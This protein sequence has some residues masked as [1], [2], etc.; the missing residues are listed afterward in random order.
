MINAQN[1]LLYLLLTIILSTYSMDI[2]SE[3]D[4]V[5]EKIWKYE[6]DFHD[7]TNTVQA[8]PKEFENLLLFVDGEGHFFALDKYTG[9]LIYSVK[10]GVLAGRRGF[11]VDQDSGNVAIVASDAAR[12][13]LNADATLF[14]IDARSGE[15]LNQTSTDWGVVEP[16]ISE[17]CIITFGA[18]DG[19]IKCYDRK[20]EEIIWQ[21]ELGTYARIWSNSLLSEKHNILYFVTSDAGDIV[22]KDRTEDIYSSALVGINVKTGSIIFSRQMIKDGVW[23][24]DG[25]GKPI[26]IEGFQNDDEN[27]YDMI[28][29]LNK[30]GTI[31]ALN[32]I[33][34]S[35]IKTNQFEEFLF[36]DDAE[37]SLIS[38]NTQV[39]PNW[40]D[41]VIDVS[42]ELD[43]LRMNEASFD[44]LRHVKYGDFIPPSVDY[45][46]ITRGLHGGPQWFGGEYFRS[47]EEDFLAI[48]YNN[49]AWILRNNY[50]EDFWIG[51]KIYSVILRIK[52]LFNYIKNL[53]IED[54]S[55][56]VPDDVDIQSGHRWIQTE[57]SNSG[58]R[59]KTMDFLYKWMNIKA[60][61]KNYY[62]NCASCHRNDREGRFQSELEGSGFV[63]SLVGYTLTDK[64]KYGKDY[65]KFISVH[66]GNLD[67]SEE[68]VK[69]IFQH[70]E[71]YDRE[72]FAKGKY[73]I[74]GFWQSLLAK[75][76]LPLNKEPWGG[77]AV[78]NLNS[79][80]KI[81][82]ITV[83]EMKDNNGNI[84]DSSIIFGGLGQIN[85]KGESLLVG[86]VDPKAYY[87]SL[88]TGK[89]IQ[90]LDLVRSG[91]VQ[92]HLTT[93]NGCEAWVVVETGG[94]YSFYERNKNGFTV[95]TFINKSS[96]S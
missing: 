42:L 53:F 47:F 13:G 20:L 18:R 70:F 33:D 26:L 54:T 79:G 73:R 90:T 22:G 78:I 3:D 12:V 95:E 21:T 72:Q 55:S 15:I 17:E 60:Y 49:N 24:F 83:G 59:A 5:F 40:P 39:I 81:H 23:D 46:V 82:D 91:S 57:W 27:A 56:E 51:S 74:T 6:T 69:E 77:I 80:K 25:V 52:R 31:F 68:D 10:L 35:N 11:T 19:I 16:V 9:R 75:D 87:V 71:K 63:P 4:L 86:T 88:V 50:A 96:C 41:R 38:S 89:V 44:I 32:A 29:G 48:P 84:F 61:N 66:A 8:K 2:S 62:E 76:S 37:L 85:S 67:I 58:D 7:K 93:I 14:L 94:R 45:D 92:P 65:S 30:T 34:G 43:D 28:V 36:P 64:Y 1:K